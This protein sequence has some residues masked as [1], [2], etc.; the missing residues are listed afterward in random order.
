M[1]LRAAAGTAAGLVGATLLAACGGAAA[2]IST[3]SVSASVSAPAT[4]TAATSAAATTTT[5]SSTAVS[6]GSA[7]SSAATTSATSSPAA[8]T[9][10][11]ASTPATAAGSS[12]A[13]VAAASRAAAAPGELRYTTQ[14]VS[15]PFSDIEGKV[16]QEF[17]QQNP[18]VKINYE[19]FPNQDLQQKLT[20]LAAAGTSSDCADIETK[21]MPGFYASGMLLDLTAYAARAKITADTYFPQEWN[22]AHIGGKLL[23]MPLD[24]QPIVI[25][26]N[27]DV[28]AAHG[29]PLPPAKWDDPSWTWDEL[30]ARAQKLTTSNGAAKTF[31]VSWPLDWRDSLE[32]IWGNGG[33]VL[34][35][36]H[37]T[38][39][40][41]MATTTDGFQY[42]ADLINKYHVHPNADEAKTLGA[43]LDA[44]VNGKIAMWANN[45][46]EAF[47]IAAKKQDV[48]YDIAPM[49]SGKAGAFTRNPA[50]SVMVATGSKSPDQAFA[51]AAYVTGPAGQSEL[52]AKAGLGVPPYRTV[53]ESADFLKPQVPGADGRN[54]Q[55]VLDMLESSHYKYTP[56]TTIY[57]QMVKLFTPLYSQVLQGTISAVQ[58]AQQVD[59]PLNDLLKQV[60]QL[61]RGFLGD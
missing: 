15:K 3:A 43:T 8:S 50:D 18:N 34:S 57:P 2:T 61:A 35:A 33:D 42:H 22:K 40:I 21:W 53:A 49:P 51:L 4:S 55:M 58:F 23:I 12:S 48:N 30:V 10:A 39:T 32:T 17:Q 19:L 7:S 27:K 36:D 60:P 28:F 59:G 11:A 56:V 44:F 54:F 9:S 29:V 14:N 47:Y 41:T 25:F 45:V 31:G 38:S 37:T 46:T 16:V 20:V 24:L 6:T 52:V 1:V 26:Y 13:T 5:A